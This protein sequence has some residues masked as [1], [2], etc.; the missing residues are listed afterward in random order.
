M[1]GLWVRASPG[2]AN[3]F[4]WRVQIRPPLVKQ[5]WQLWDSNP[6]PFGLVPKTSALDHSA[7]LP[8]LP[9]KNYTF[10]P[11]QT[12]TM[13]PLKIV[14]VASCEV[15]THD[16]WFTRPVL[17][18]WAKEANAFSLR[19]GFQSTLPTW[20]GLYWKGMKRKTELVTPMP[21]ERIELSTPGLQDQCSATEL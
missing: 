16:P 2:A 14:M 17:Y 1:P 4:L 20:F 21:P 8:L 9:L 7:K 6:R 11:I 12:R 15:W 13:A 18:H 19:P 3:L 10:A 5:S